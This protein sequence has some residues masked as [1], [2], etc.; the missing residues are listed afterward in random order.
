[1]IRLCDLYVSCMNGHFLRWVA[2][3]GV[4]LAIGGSIAACGSSN[5]STS[6]THGSGGASSTGGPGGA[7]GSVTSF[8]GS[9]GESGQ[10]LQVTPTALQTLDVAIG[11]MTPTV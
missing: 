6:G 11:G 3:V 2:G 10:G 9:G 8:V 4:A 1:M 5:Q 7:G